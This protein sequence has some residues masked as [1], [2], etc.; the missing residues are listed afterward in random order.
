MVLIGINSGYLRSKPRFSFNDGGLVLGTDSGA[1]VLTAL[2]PY[3][4]LA[5]REGRALLVEFGSFGL[6]SSYEVAL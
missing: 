6:K 4:A 2:P 1:L 3:A 5:V